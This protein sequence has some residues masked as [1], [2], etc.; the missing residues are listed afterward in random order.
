M[1]Q[2]ENPMASLSQEAKQLNVRLEKDNGEWV[3]IIPAHPDMVNDEE[4][5]F[6]A[7]SEQE[8]LDEARAFRAIESSQVYKFQYEEEQ[9]VYKVSFNGQEFTG[10]LLAPTYRDA[11]AAYAE[12][13]NK[14]APAE[15]PAPQP[16]KTRQRKVQPDAQQPTTAVPVRAPPWTPNP[17]PQPGDTEH[18]ATQDTVYHILASIFDDVAKALR[19]KAQ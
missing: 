5:G 10:K 19:E 17:P 16:K 9:D 12:F 3:A 18:A 2:P 7:P 11:Q 6:P 8:A 13:I 15:A 4:V 14:D 1:L